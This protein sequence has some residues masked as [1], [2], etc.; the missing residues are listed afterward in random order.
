MIKIIKDGKLEKFTKTCPDCGCVFE[1]E[2]SDTIKEYNYQFAYSTYPILYP[3]T[4]YVRCPCCGRKIVHD[5]G[6]EE[7]NTLTYPNV[8]YTTVNS[9]EK[10][11]EDCLYY[12]EIKLNHEKQYKV[13]DTPCTWCPKMQPKCTSR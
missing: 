6:C 1:Y 4:R 8:I 3:Y 5:T 10:G 9:G 7:V 2:L 11:C 12:Q 13:G